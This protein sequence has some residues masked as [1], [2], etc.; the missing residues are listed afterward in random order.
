MNKSHKG[1]HIE[2][3]AV[4]GAGTISQSRFSTNNLNYTNFQDEPCKQAL[5]PVNSSEIKKNCNIETL[6]K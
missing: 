3:S 2:E 6:Q 5:I 1:E 4:N